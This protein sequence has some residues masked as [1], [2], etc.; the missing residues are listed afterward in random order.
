MTFFF[1][2]QIFV[3]LMLTIILGEVSGRGIA[4]V[5]WSV[6]TALSMIGE[7]VARR[8]WGH[9][10]SEPQE[11]VVDEVQIRWTRTLFYSWRRSNLILTAGTIGFVAWY[12]ITR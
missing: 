3:M 2:F 12:F 6:L 11:G 10:I 7:V 1:E 5:V 4:L 9:L 8:R